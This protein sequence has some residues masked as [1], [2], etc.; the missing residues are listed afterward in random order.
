VVVGGVAGA[1]A[2]AGSSQKDRD[3]N[4]AMVNIIKQLF[5]IC[6]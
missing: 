5:F 6:L 3:N 4:K 2:G 1:G